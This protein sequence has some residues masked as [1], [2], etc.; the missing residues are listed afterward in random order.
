MTFSVEIHSDCTEITLL[1]MTGQDKDVKVLIQPDD[2]VYI[3]Q[4][5]PRTDHVDVIEM[6]WQMLASLSAALHCEDGV[7]SIVLPEEEK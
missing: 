7:Y 4:Q 3:R 1:D 6:T 5:C 2:K